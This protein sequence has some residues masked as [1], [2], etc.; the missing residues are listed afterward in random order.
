MPTFITHTIYLVLKEV[1][2]PLLVLYLASKF[3]NKD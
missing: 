3:T 2:F 1:G